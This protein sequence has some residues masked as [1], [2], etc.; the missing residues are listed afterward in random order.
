MF[1][2]RVV[3]LLIVVFAIVTVGSLTLVPVAGQAPQAQSPQS[4]CPDDNPAAFH[5][6]A[7][8][9]I[10]SFTPPRTADG[11][12]DFGGLWRHRTPAHEDLEEHVKTIDDSGGPSVIVD[13]PDGKA[14]MQPWAEAK[15]Q[16]NEA[17]HIDQNIMC[18][19]SGVPR[20]LYMGA[21]QFLQTPNYIALLSEESHAYRLVAMDGRPHLGKNILLWQG[22]SRGRWEGNT[23]VVETTNQNGMPWLDQRGRFYTDAAQVVERLT[24]IDANTMHYEATLDDPNVYTRPFTMAFPLRRNMQK[25]FE[26]WEESCYEGESNVQHLNNLGYTR[27]PGFTAKQAK[28]ARSAWEKKR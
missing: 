11:K 10:K 5:K 25:G 21:Y 20:H 1:N 7:H 16:Q 27:Y 23:L 2:T 22:D 6:C 8:D 26:L 19:Q 28:D 3:A 24:L 12:P 4:S 15:R 13:P 9:H 14:P 17:K 18:Y